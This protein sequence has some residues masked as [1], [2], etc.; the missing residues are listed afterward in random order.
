[1]WWKQEW[2]ENLCTTEQYK[3]IDKLFRKQETGLELI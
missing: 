2:L 1:M 3:Q